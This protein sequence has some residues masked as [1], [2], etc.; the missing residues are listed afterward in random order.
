E[1]KLGGNERYTEYRARHLFTGKRG[2]VR[3]RIYHA[4]PYQD[5]AVRQREQRL[6]SNA[7]RSIADVPGHPNILNVHSF[8]PAEDSS[9]FVLVTD[10]AHGQV[11]RMHIKKP[12]LALTFDQK[13]RII[14]DVLTAL[15]H[16]HNHQ[17]IHRN[18][19]PDAIIVSTDGHARLGSFDYAR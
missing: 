18:L 3:L 6:I 16:A 15:E 8:F 5:E 7:F 12:S 4:D 2:S 17:V 1:E 19:T 9:Y 14:R 13:I 11:L 10:D